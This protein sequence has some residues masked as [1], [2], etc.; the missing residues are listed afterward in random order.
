MRSRSLAPRLLPLLGNS[1]K[2]GVISS[3]CLRPSDRPSICLTPPPNTECV[4]NQEDA[5]GYATYSAYTSVINAHNYLS[6]VTSS[7]T[8]YKTWF[9]A[10]ST[11]SLAA[12]Q[13]RYQLMMGASN[14]F[15][16]TN[17]DCTCT[18]S[19]MFAYEYPTVYAPSLRLDFAQNLWLTCLVLRVAM[20]T[21]TYAVHSGQHPQLVR[22]LRQEH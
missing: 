13:S 20:A 16:Y 4:P 19:G 10:Y 21:C 15:N 3:A 2:E 9:G 8:R 7:T 6:T 17:Y 11:S 5:I 14:L 12:V 18:D 22:T 1:N